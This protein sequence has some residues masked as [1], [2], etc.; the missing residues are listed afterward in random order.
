VQPGIAVLQYCESVM[1]YA[2]VLHETL[3]EGGDPRD[4]LTMTR[5]M[6]NRTFQGK[7]NI[8]VLCFIK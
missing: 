2:Q 1:M 7:K 5:K 3:E 8:V 6:W 4:G